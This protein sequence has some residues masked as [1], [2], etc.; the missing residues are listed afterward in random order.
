ME[1]ARRVL[2]RLER[3]DRLRS[4]GGSRTLVLAEV[5]KLLEEG[6]AWLA[7]EPSE[8]E[9]ARR[10]LESCRRRLD[11]PGGSPASTPAA[12]A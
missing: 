2:D 12:A 4:A 7:V 5:R 6:E 1:E 11:E 10:A 9:R 8:T 3:I